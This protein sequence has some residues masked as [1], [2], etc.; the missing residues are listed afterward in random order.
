M[1]NGGIDRMGVYHRIFQYCLRYK[2]RLIAGLV[3]SFF[4]SI[5]NGLSLTSL[6]PIFDSLGEGKAE[7]QIQLTKKDQY[8]IKNPNL[9]PQGNFESVER[10]LAQ[11]K[12][13]INDRLSGMEKDE[14]VF[15][16]CSLIFPIYVL[17]LLCL[18]GTI[19]FINTC[20]LLAI[21]DIRNELY[22]KLE[23]LPI[24]YFVQEKTGILMSRVINDVDT[25]G[26]V[27]SS[28]AKDAINDFFYIITH[29][30]L[31]LY[32]SWKMTI[33]VF[34]V[35]PIATG[36]V[37]YFAKK[38]RKATRNQ[39]ERL[40]MLNGDLQEV[41]SGIRVIRAFS[42][43]E[44]ESKRFWEVNDDLY[45]KTFKGHFYHQIGPSITDLTASMIALLFL[46]FGAYLMETPGFSKGMFLA[47]FLTMGFIIRPMKQMSVLVNLVNSSRSAGERVF[48]L[49]DEK[50]VAPESPNPI[51]PPIQGS[52]ELNHVSF[53]YPGSK[54]ESL[55][56]L[57]LHVKPNQTIAIV[58]S[59]GAGKSTLIDLLPRIIDPDQGE[60]K[61]DGVNTKDWN[62]KALRQ[63]I[64]IVSQN[65]FLFNASI[66]ENILYGSEG[67][68][69]L[70]VEDAAS[71]A[72][73]S[74]FI[75][76]FP[77]GYETMVG[78]RGVMLSGGQ[79]QRISIA[80][81]FLKNPEIL[82]LD[83]ATSALDNESEK[84]VQN[85][86]YD[87]YQNKTVIMI[88]HRLTTV[89][90]ADCIYYL[91]DG[92][93]IESGTH[94]ELMSRDSSYKKLFDLQFAST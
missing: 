23:F 90:N 74:E 71:K 80:R 37:S 58:G 27:V 56:N 47:F 2:G 28:D 24:Q 21:R 8:W 13:K 9:E 38:I 44:K 36:P 32:L 76:A 69:R 42:M 19:Y 52:V 84:L 72:Y 45:K 25:V 22:Q 93:I 70:E 12:K 26:K 61:I 46:S 94:N 34:I 65:V 15:F 66:Y 41:L 63:R 87:L 89:V 11:T 54:K 91:Q 77:E 53:T 55:S 18:A 48:E 60:V 31:M 39:Q 67:S 92:T 17:K 20:G 43:E 49:L 82:I 62:L 1:A 33:A 75:N 73:A 6:I 50:S 4:V 51:T 10:F 83:E 78:E 35:L 57:N 86:L 7:F 30:C 59:S 16:F 88:A 64:S 85:A 40:S 14:L 5:F 79:K 3:L 81:A 68:T 29:L